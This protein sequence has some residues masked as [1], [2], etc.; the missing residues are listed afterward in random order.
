MIPYSPILLSPHF[1]HQGMLL[2]KEG[3]PC[4]Q[5]P[6]SMIKA[7]KGTG[8]DEVA[9]VFKNGYPSGPNDNLGRFLDTEMKPPCNSYMKEKKKELSPMH[10][11]MFIGY[12]VS[13]HVVLAYVKRA[14]KI[15]GMM[16]AHLMGVADPVSRKTQSGETKFLPF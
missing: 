3:I 4:L 7:P 12:G 1:N 5:I 9:V 2:K 8:S 6:K 10:Q 13:E 16:H 14:R 15:D 11:R